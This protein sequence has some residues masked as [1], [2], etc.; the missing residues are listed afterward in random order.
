MTTLIDEPFLNS[1]YAFE[2]VS[3]RSST[4]LRSNSD[5]GNN[6]IFIFSSI[7]KLCPRVPE[8]ITTLV[9]GYRMHRTQQNTAKRKDFPCNCVI[10]RA[11]YPCVLTVLIPASSAYI[12]TLMCRVADTRGLIIALLMRTAYA[13]RWRMILRLPRYLHHSVYRFCPLIARV[14]LHGEARQ[15]SIFFFL[16]F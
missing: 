12:F 11:F 3:F 13:L 5:R 15:G 16:T 8:A 7:F 4:S 1:T 2:A 10:H 14:L 9:P 6:S